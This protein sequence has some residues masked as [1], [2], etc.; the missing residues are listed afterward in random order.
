MAAERYVELRDKYFRLPPNKRVN[1]R[2]LSILS[3]FRAPFSELV[4]DW[5]SN[6]TNAN[7][8]YV[9]RDRSKLKDVVECIKG[10]NPAKFPSTLKSECLIQ[11]KLSVKRRGSPNNFSLICLPTRNDFKRN[12]KRI[13]LRSNDPVFTERLLSDPNE[14]ER[15]KL[16]LQHKKLL[17]RLRARRIREKR[18]KQV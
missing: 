7:D 5:N 6:T 15:K 1:Y 2:K 8:F 14:K 3:P 16:R 10:L 17:K 12:L 13:Y 4:R 11:L 9:L 18:K